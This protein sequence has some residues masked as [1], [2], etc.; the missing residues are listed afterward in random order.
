MVGN[1]IFKIHMARCQ[2]YVD[3]HGDDNRLYFSRSFVAV[4]NLA[5]C[6]FS[7]PFSCA[8]FSYRQHQGLVRNSL[9]SSL[10]RSEILFSISSATGYLICADSLPSR[11]R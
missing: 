6:A 4:D 3:N 11:L 1:G 7:Q 5:G 9:A 8:L 2:S 10:T